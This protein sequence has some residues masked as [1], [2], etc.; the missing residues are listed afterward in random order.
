M[1][2][3]TLGLL[4][5]L[6]TLQQDVRH[7]NCC[8]CVLH[9]GIRSNIR[10]VRSE[11][12][13]PYRSSSKYGIRIRW[14][15]RRKKLLAHNSTARNKKNR[16]LCTQ[17]VRTSLTPLLYYSSCASSFPCP[18]APFARMKPLESHTHESLPVVVSRAEDL[19][20]EQ[21][22]PECT[23][24][25]KKPH[26]CGQSSTPAQA[27]PPNRRTLQPRYSSGHKAVQGALP[28]QPCGTQR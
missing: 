17:Q 9:D 7:F 2:A 10:S 24:M 14:F 5:Y 6:Q 28:C 15:R 26:G 12:S 3:R 11:R 22:G 21:T 16:R 25:R 27:C 8:C 1:C 20:G 13:L 23:P 19:C 18:L 4:L